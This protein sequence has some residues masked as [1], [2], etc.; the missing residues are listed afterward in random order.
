MRR[1]AFGRSLAA[2]LAL[3]AGCAGYP[4]LDQP[5]AKR[6]PPGTGGY[7]QPTEDKSMGTGAFSLTFEIPPGEDEFVV[8]V[9]VENTGADRAS[10]TLVVSWK[11]PDEEREETQ[12]V[13]LA[14]GE[15]ADYE[16]T[17]PED[18]DLSFDWR[19]A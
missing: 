6:E 8:V 17:F 5:G 1:R 16:F 13:D 11:G 12:L 14:G 19:E 4:P 9:T 2:G 10:S 7:G 3:F 18:G 15:T